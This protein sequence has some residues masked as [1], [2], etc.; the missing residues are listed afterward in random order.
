M[1]VE[2]RLRRLE[3]MAF[4][5]DGLQRSVTRLGMNAN[6]LGEALMQVDRNQQALSKLGRELESVQSEKASKV[7][8]NDAADKTLKELKSYRRKVLQRS[9]MAGVS[10][11]GVLAILGMLAGAYVESARQQAELNCQRSEARASAVADYLRE[12]QES[13]T[14][15]ALQESAGR[16]VREIDN[17]AC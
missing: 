13:S 9:Y 5:G 12:V 7:E 3:D 4:E 17:V 11:L 2:E 8:V 1:P 16:I 10:M 6:A 15:P 14:N